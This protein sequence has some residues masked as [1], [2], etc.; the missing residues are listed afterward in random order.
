MNR[1]T[2]LKKVFSN[3]IILI[4]LCFFVFF[5]YKIYSYKQEENKQKQ[6]NNNII[7]SAVKNIETDNQKENNN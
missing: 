7:Q 6:L 4:S 2:K 1:G 5:A 3:L